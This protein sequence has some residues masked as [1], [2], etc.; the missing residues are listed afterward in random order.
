[1]QSR[2]GAMEEGK[3]SATVVK[4]SQNKVYPLR[5]LQFLMLFLVLGSGFFIFSMFMTRFFGF[6]TASPAIRAAIQACFR[7]ANSLDDWVRPPS[8]LMHRMNDTELF[9]RA[10][11][12]PRIKEYPFRRVPKIAFMFLAKGPLPLAPL[13]E[14][15]FKG[16]EELY[17]IYVHAL[18]NYVANFTTSS[19]FYGKQIPSQV[20]QTL[21][22]V[23]T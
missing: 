22:S 5:V 9:W 7:E 18:P 21:I 13:W 4:T 11:F 10:S 19:V 17:S 1:M 15:F 16:H 12:V 8:T 3:E 23:S 6:Q 20:L 14:R 2:I